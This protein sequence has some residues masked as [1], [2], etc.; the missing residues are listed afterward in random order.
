[1]PTALVRD[2]HA[3]TEREGATL[4]VLLLAAY[5]ALL[6]LEGGRPDVV[7]TTHVFNRLDRGSEHL[8]GNFLTHLLVRCRW[9]GDPTFAELLRMA[10]DA[11]LATYARKEFPVWNVI[12]RLGWADFSRRSP[13]GQYHLVAHDDVDPLPPS[14]GTLTARFEPVYLGRFPGEIGLYAYHRAAEDQLRARFEW[15]VALFEEATITRL[16]DRLDELLTRVVA[17]PE[18]RLSALLSGLGWR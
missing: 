10:R 6:T 15:D 13:M 2:V 1:M 12:D 9:A 17:Q 4:Y 3:L 18:R 14:A 8:V 7:V 16:R 5:T 11:T